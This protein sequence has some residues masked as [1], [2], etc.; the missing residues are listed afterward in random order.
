MC[1]ISRGGNNRPTL[2]AVTNEQ[3]VDKD[4]SDIL[5]LER[6]KLNEMIQE[7]LYEKNLIYTEEQ[8]GT[9]FLVPSKSIA[10]ISNHNPLYKKFI[11]V[12][13]RD[14]HKV[15]IIDAYNIWRGIE[16][17]DDENY[18][19][20]KFLHALTLQLKKPFEVKSTTYL[21]FSSYTLYRK[22]D[23]HKKQEHAG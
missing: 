18:F 22:N 20:D 17:E 11:P 16:E 2:M 21:L 9:L 8:Q 23:E 6:R 10:I 15:F 19:M 3:M 14:F 5:L 4:V 7:A 1:Y 12:L 13:E